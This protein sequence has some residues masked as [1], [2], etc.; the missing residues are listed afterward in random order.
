MKRSLICLGFTI[1]HL[2]LFA[3]KKPVATPFIL[4]GKLTNYPEK[5][6]FLQTY[7]AKRE[8][9]VDTIHV[10]ADGSFYFT[11]SSN[12]NAQKAMIGFGSMFHSDIFVAPGYNLILT[13]DSK[14]FSALSF[15]QNKKLTG[16]GSE[17]NSFLFKRDAIMASNKMPQEWYE[18]NEKDFIT[19]LK[20]SNKLNDSLFRVVF[21]HHAANDNYFAFFKQMTTLDNTFQN[22]YYVVV[23]SLIDTSFSAAQMR[24][25]VTDN[26]DKTILNDLYNEKYLVSEW[27]RTAMSDYVSYLQKLECKEAPASCEGKN[28]NV[29]LLD[30]IAKHYKGKVKQIALFR[31]MNNNLTYCR[32]FA[33]LNTYKK[34]FP[35]FVSM[36]E[37]KTNQQKIDTLFAKMENTL[38]KTQVGQ[39]APAFVAEDSTG[40]QYSIENYKGKVVYLDLWASWCGPCR[41]E[42][43]YLKKLVEKFNGDASIAFVSVAVLDKKDKWKEALADDTPQ[44][45][46]LFDTNG[47]V[48]SAYVANSI[49]KFILINKEGKIVSFDA[50]V[51]S[52]GE[53][54]EKLLRA[55]I[56]K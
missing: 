56:A 18:M 20:K 17:S 15:T 50:P 54:I 21:G 44:W 11:D 45:L 29:Q 3:Q 55:E 14:E 40:R 8:R 2:A 25:F 26:V 46:Q 1:L 42:T 13:S 4:Q 47:S 33:E 30:E 10:K 31:F 34:E 32:S 24:S 12:I 5:F 38:L 43:P 41:H 6:F 49:P 9:R 51:P 22:F 28:Y 37:D 16:K 36:L 52:S 48:Q 27:Y 19:F 39:L 35:Q 23:H 7:N 53:E